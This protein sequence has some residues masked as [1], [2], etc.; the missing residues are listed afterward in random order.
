MLYEFMLIGVYVC[1]EG[2]GGEG[3]LGFFFFVLCGGEWI[4]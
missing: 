4:G 3:G 1:V 2:G